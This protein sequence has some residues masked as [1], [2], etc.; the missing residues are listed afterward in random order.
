MAL[1]E[2]GVQALSDAGIFAYIIPFLLAIAIVY[3]ILDHVSVPKDKSIRGMI[4]LLAGFLALPLGGTLFPFLEGVVLGFMVIVA[5]VLTLLIMAEATGIKQG[6]G[7]HIWE[8]HPKWTGAVFIMIA[9]VIFIAAGG[10]ELIGLNNIR[11]G[12]GL[13]LAFFLVI[14]A[15]GVWWIAG[16]KKD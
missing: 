6:G 1:V 15:L 2:R 9:L 14:I 10:P 3:G 11:I 4:A 5:T 7:K 8:S 12:G 13:G 16:G